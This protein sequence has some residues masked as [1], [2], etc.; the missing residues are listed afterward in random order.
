MGTFYKAIIYHFIDYSESGGTYAFNEL[1]EL[2]H[3]TLE[4]LKKIM[5]K[6]YGE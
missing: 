3:G 6:K 4:G 5:F 1:D 2:R